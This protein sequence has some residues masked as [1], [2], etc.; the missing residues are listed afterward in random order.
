MKKIAQAAVAA[1]VGACAMSAQAAT[2]TYTLEVNQATNTWSLFGKASDGDNAGIAAW[3]VSLNNANLPAVIQAPF[4]IYQDQDDMEV[5]QIGFG[6][7]EVNNSNPISSAQDI[8]EP[9]VYGFGQTA[10]SIAQPPS[11]N[12]LGQRNSVNYQADLLLATDTYT[13]VAPSFMGG[14]HFANVY[15]NSSGSTEISA[16]VILNP[17]FVPEPG[18]ALLL[19]AAPLIARRRRRS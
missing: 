17:T 7:L 4:L 8:G 5:H 18:S 10:G 1:V 2:V 3:G 15:L 12:F 19:A 6:S 13:G 9:P 11:T 14:G 16:T